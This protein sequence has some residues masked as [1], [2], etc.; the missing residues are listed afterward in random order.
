M[1][2]KVTDNRGRKIFVLLALATIAL[3][4]SILYN[5]P[6]ARAQTDPTVKVT[7]YDGTSKT[8]TLTELQNMSATSM[9]GG[10]YQTNQHVVNNGLYTGISLLQLCNQVGGITPT[11]NV[12]VT[13]QGTNVFTYEMVAEGLNYN[14]AYK[15]YNNI[16]GTPQ[17]QTQPI[18]IILA[19]QVNGSDLP[20][21]SQPAPRLVIV[22]PEGLLCDG[23][24]GRSVTQVTATNSAPVP[25]TNPTPTPL[26][27][28]ISTATPT[29]TPTPSPS[30]TSTPTT[31]P[32][33]SSLPTEQPTT[34][35]S[36]SPTPSASPEPEQASSDYII[37]TAVVSAV[38]IIAIAAF[39]IV[40]RRK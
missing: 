32:T 24:G 19:Y 21:S 17:N 36:T 8:F 11:C 5:A 1:Q 10:F 18:T 23:S 34:T 26:P 37:V 33:L 7:G 22:G 12:T 30:Q 13:G 16:T 39:V 38:A 20:S 29:A 25:T 27:T 40:R 3:S 14:L 9:Y 15:T 35:S 28:A 4:T 31:T 2:N 6:Q